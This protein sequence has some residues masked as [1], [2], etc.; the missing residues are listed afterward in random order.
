MITS[1]SMNRRYKRR[2]VLLLLLLAIAIPLVAE[3]FEVRVV[4]SADD[5][6][7]AN[8]ESFLKRELRSLGDVRIRAFDSE[9]MRYPYWSV[10]VV[11]YQ[12]TGGLNGPFAMAAIITEN[13]N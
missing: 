9:S 13:Y 1:E 10:R 6:I 12:M 5:P 3:Q 8:I 7:K 11:A 4:V 2:T